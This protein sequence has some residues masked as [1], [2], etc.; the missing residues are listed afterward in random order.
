[1]PEQGP[2]G[3]GVPKGLSSFYKK[4]NKITKLSWII[5]LDAENMYGLLISIIFEFR[6]LESDKPGF[7]ILSCVDSNLEVILTR[8]WANDFY[9]A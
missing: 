8:P 7:P 1:M 6:L 9:P 5:S 4:E 3:L 2:S